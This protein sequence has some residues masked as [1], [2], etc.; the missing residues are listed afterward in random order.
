MVLSL[1]L[2]GSNVIYAQTES[3]TTNVTDIAK[4][5]SL[6]K[7]GYDFE[8]SNFSF[9]YG[10]VFVLEH[11]NGNIGIIKNNGQWLIEPYLGEEYIRDD[12]RREIGEI[13]Y[14]KKEISG[15]TDLIYI[16]V[17]KGEKIFTITFNENNKDEKLKERVLLIVNYLFNTNFNSLPKGCDYLTIDNHFTVKDGFLIF[18]S[19]T[20]DTESVIN[21]NG[22]LIISGKRNALYL[23][24]NI[25]YIDDVNTQGLL[26]EIK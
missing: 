2:V 12:F 13:Y 5:N 16:D 11:E 6:I 24:N 21:K 3:D 25:F 9:G 4:L 15:V 17:E 1:W 14:Y 23:G 20:D 26:M 18:K 8:E 10:K 7:Q 22:E 19:E